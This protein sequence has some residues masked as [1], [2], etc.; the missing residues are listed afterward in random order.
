MA[1]ATCK[2]C[3][4]MVSGSAATC[5]NCGAKNPTQGKAVPSQ[6]PPKSSPQK[7][8]VPPQFKKNLGL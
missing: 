8:I 6:N 2:D 5:P 4:K 1:L 3:G 7:G